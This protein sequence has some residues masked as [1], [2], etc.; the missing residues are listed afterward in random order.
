[1]TPSPANGAVRL[2]DAGQ[3]DAARIAELHALSWRHAYRGA[4]SEEFLAGDIVADRRA[5][6]H[7]RLSAPAPGQ[8]VVVADAGGPLLGFGC[9]QTGADARW[10]TLLDNLHVL[11]SHHRGGIGRRLLG[12]LAEWAQARAPGDGLFL[13]V[14]QS[15]TA[16]QSFYRRLGAQEAGCDVWHPPGG[17]V[18][19]RFRMAWSLPAPLLMDAG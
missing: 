7:G 10:G 13:W 1:M 19:P 12:R 5:L 17:G 6:W 9:V 11:P 16:A 3:A 2:R 15:N 18:V 8:C 14:L 4:L